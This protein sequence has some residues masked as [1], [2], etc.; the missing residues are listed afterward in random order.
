MSTIKVIGNGESRSSIDIEKL[1]GPLVGCN[2]I[3]RDY[4]VDYLVCVD[5]RMVQEA[6]NS[7]ANDYSLVYTRE[8]WHPQFKQHKRIRILPDLPYS[9]SD[10]W[11]EPFQW[12]SGPY[13]V[14]LGALKSKK[15]T[16]HLIGFDMY[17]DTSTVNNI[18]KDTR[19]YD[20]ADKRA[21]D[22]R[23]WIHQIGKVFQCFPKTKFIVYN[24]HIKLKE[25]WIYPNVMVDTI[26][27][28][29]YNS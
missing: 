26:S 16:V 29:S 2:A 1:D 20:R 11:D 7:N 5:R 12:G 22:P 9:G 27:N 19:N 14:L 24:K 13:A 3:M 28:I 18:Y 23:Y 21:V 17:S 15:E 8:E 25:S 6:I 4:K 10:R